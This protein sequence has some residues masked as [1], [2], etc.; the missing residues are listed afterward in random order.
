MKLQEKLFK[1]AESVACLSEFPRIQIGAVI[2]KKSNIIAVGVNQE[3]SHPTQK[4]FNL[5]RF[6]GKLDTC[7]HHLHAEMDAFL[8]VR[9]TDLSK[10]SIYVFRRNANNELAMSRPCPACMAMIK[11]S[12]IK[13]VYYTTN[14]GFAAERLN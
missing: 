6:N 12:G 5:N 7:Q 1:V 13:K 8:K 10:A 4:E 14:D 2:A 3:K 9:N 11:K